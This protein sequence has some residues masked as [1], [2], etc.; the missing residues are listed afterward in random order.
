MLRRKRLNC[1]DTIAQR[2]A[3]LGC[4]DEQVQRHIIQLNRKRPEP[5]HYRI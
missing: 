4:S 3:K 1:S 2:L 5:K